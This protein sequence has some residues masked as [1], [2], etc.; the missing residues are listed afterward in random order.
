MYIYIYIYICIYT[1]IYTHLQGRSDEGV[2][3]TLYSCLLLKQNASLLVLPSPLCMS[4]WW[5]SIGFSGMLCFR[6]SGF[7]IPVQNPSPISVLGVKSPHLQCLT[8]NKSLLCSN[9]KSSNTTSLNSR[10]YYCL[11]KPC[12]FMEESPH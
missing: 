7:K 2:S 10:V 3:L 11:T 5:T 8:V 6:I 12:K 4:I 1:H 9:P